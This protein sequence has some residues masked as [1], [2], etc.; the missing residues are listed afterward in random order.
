MRII[1]IITAVVVIFALYVLVFERDSFDKLASGNSIKSVVEARLEE[2]NTSA[3]TEISDQEVTQQ[4]DNVS[5][6]VS[7]VVYASSSQTLGSYVILRGETEAARFVEVRSETFGQVVS[8]PLRKGSF[9]KKNDILCK[10]DEGTR[11]TALA[12]AAAKLEEA[13]ALIPQTEAKL[14]EANSR[15]EEAKI[16]FNA[17][18]KLS[19]GGYASETRV[20]SAEAAMR[21]AEAGVATATAG[22]ESTRARIQS[23]EAG[24]AAAEKEI[25]RLII[26]APFEGTLESDTAEIGSLLQPGALCGTIIQLNPI[27]LVGF[28]PETELSRVKLGA[29]VKAKLT[30][31]HEIDGNVTFLSRSADTTTR[32]F[33]VE[34]NVP[35]D[36]LEIRDGQTVEIA[37]GSDGKKA[38]LLPQSALTLN[39]DGILGIRF[40]DEQNTTRFAAVNLEQDSK[41]GVWV[42]GLDDNVDVIVIGQEFVREGVKVSA[43]YKDISL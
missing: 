6:L 16:N 35:N 36:Q 43:T 28:L 29:P 4:I 14:D 31:G 39:D 9:V 40:I 5:E 24:V 33:R 13:K 19:Q 22:F 7:V 20:A 25:E 21:S 3:E 30:S 23:A 41:E 17:A 8:E 37:I 27:K 26:K 42:S 1:S 34:V 12:D 2:Q 10:L 11:K 18:T 32:T 15:L 38:H